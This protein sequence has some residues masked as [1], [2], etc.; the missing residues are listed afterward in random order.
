MKRNKILTQQLRGE[1]GQTNICTLFL[2]EH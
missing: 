1:T 2:Y